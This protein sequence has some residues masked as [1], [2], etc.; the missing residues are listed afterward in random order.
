MTLATRP[1]APTFST[2]AETGTVSRLLSIKARRPRHDINAAMSPSF[3]PTARK[4]RLTIRD[5]VRPTQPSCVGLGFEQVLPANYAS[6]T[7]RLTSTMYVLRT[8][9]WAESI[10]TN[11]PLGSHLGCRSQRFGPSYRHGE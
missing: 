9:S 3:T 4:N 1:P 6:A 5:A 10:E 2:L 11:C 7:I 8:P